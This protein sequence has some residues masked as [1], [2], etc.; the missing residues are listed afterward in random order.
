MSAMSIF[1]PLSYFR[2]AGALAAL[3]A[4]MFVFLAGAHA[5]RGSN[6]RTGARRANASAT[7]SPSPSPQRQ[8]QSARRRITPLRSS[9]TASGSRLTITS[10][11]ALNDYGA[12]R[13]G[14]YFYVV[15]PQAEAG[16]GTNVSG[17]GFSG[18][19]VR[20]S[21][22]D[23][24]YS[25]RLQPGASARVNQRFNRLDVEFTAPGGE[26]ARTQANA[27]RA[28]ATATPAPRNQNANTEARTTPP[29]NQSATRTPPIETAQ[30]DTPSIGAPP[31]TSILPQEQI[32]PPGTSEMP[33]VTASPE[34]SA[35]DNQIAQVL[36]T[37]VAAPPIAPTG[38]DTATGTSFG[39]ALARNWLW[40]IIATALLVGL[41]LFA[42][43]RASERASAPPPPPPSSLP[44]MERSAATSTA[45]RAEIE[46]ESV[47][48][49]PA[50]VVST[51]RPGAAT[52]DF[53]MA[54]S[55]VTT[56]LVVT[57]AII[58]AIAPATEEEEEDAPAEVTMARE[59]TSV[60]G[61]AAEEAAM[62]GET[63]PLGEIQPF[64]ETQPLDA[65]ETQPLDVSAAAVAAPQS[66][67]TERI[68]IEIRNL[69]DGKEYDEAVIGT[70]D[71]STRQLVGT[72]LLAAIAGRNY[73]RR[74]NALRAFTKHG[75]FDGAVRDLSEADAPA[76]RASAA[77]ALG[78]TRDHTATPTLVAALDD[79]S[80]E[81]RRASV[82]ALASLRDHAAREPLERLLERETDRNVPHILIQHAIDASP[83]S[84]P[85]APVAPT[86]AEET[87]EEAAASHET[88]FETA[89]TQT[90]EAAFAPVEIEPV[91]RTEAT[92]QET[93]TI[94]PTLDGTPE[95]VVAEPSMQAAT[96]ELVH[97][98]AELQASEIATEEAFVT[99][100]AF[101]QE[102][103]VN[104]EPGEANL[105]EALPFE[106]AEQ[107]ASSVDTTRFDDEWINLDLSGEARTE[108]QTDVTES[109]IAARAGDDESVMVMPVESQEI[110]Y[111]APPVDA[112]V[113][114][115]PD[116]IETHP[117][118]ERF[119]S[120]SPLDE[121]APTFE[122]TYPGSG[123]EV[124]ASETTPVMDTGITPLPVL[125]MRSPVPSIVRERLASP[126]VSE[127]ALGVIDL[128]RMRNEDVF[129]DICA[130]FDDSALEV[131]SA[132]AQSLYDAS[133]DRI[134]AFTRALR[135]AVP[136][137][138]RRIG[139]AIASSGLA[140]AA[141]SNLTG[142]S[143]EKTYDAFSLL[144]LMAKAGEIQPLT[145]AIETHANTEVRLAV[146]K[147]LALSGQQEILPSFRR[148]AVRGSLPPDVRAAVMEAIYQ[149]SNQPAPNTA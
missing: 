117:T 82:E 27:N 31:T 89:E 55:Y 26:Q 95:L 141:I 64:A 73:S 67:D 122:E 66:F 80:P 65:G 61:L 149:I 130:A 123:I 139:A 16:G 119:T 135:E 99:E 125:D 63:Q 142:E 8:T 62:V 107:S 29:T 6:R 109:V 105:S 39:A 20:R 11:S 33:V 85:L 48:L 132:A 13:R 128:S 28:V 83:I 52:D 84:M 42:F 136:E 92:E 81:V 146:V 30:R 38:T 143:R 137:R 74:E 126:E 72:E 68:G 69:L 140:N 108:T 114:P 118:I 19:E 93:A 127:R 25:F 49:A 44:Q 32:A 120:E 111:D 71:A 98:P 145:R 24:I 133:D 101:A 23:V 78:L 12:Y 86:V 17:R 14:D 88:I 97:S 53:T 18:A 91:S 57:P 46:P 76:E 77:R 110:I 87:V 47:S 106:T 10:D 7:P 90:G 148:L 124:F 100:E 96:D 59:E 43:A 45:T 40:V 5:Q 58:A 94:E 115:A 112:L 34:P 21:G 35:P 144:F 2:R 116:V 70:S 1:L 129:D 60:Q 131:R 51:A 75:Y 138:R 113:S 41:G 36:P 56:P 147:L 54:E 79:E 3:I 134:A 4:L 22:N 102:P 50:G 103:I 121:T 9:E 15:I 104:V 37:P